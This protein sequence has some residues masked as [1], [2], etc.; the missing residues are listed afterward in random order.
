MGEHR[1]CVGSIHVAGAGQ[2]QIMTDDVSADLRQWDV[3]DTMATQA[4]HHLLRFGLEDRHLVSIIRPPSVSVE[5]DFFD[6][7]SMLNNL[8]SDL[9]ITRSEPAS[10]VLREFATFTQ[11]QWRVSKSRPCPP[12]CVG[13]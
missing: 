3:R 9:S 8:A 11:D 7:P 13:T 1:R 5:A 12:A 4:E 10:P 2:S 6:E